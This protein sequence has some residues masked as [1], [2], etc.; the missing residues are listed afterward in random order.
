VDVVGH[1]TPVE[2]NPSPASRDAINEFQVLRKV[3]VI[4]KEVIPEVPARHDVVQARRI[5]A[6]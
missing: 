3:I 1:Q 6:T 5:D 4:Q 2:D